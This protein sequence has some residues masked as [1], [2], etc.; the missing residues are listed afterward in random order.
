MGVSKRKHFHLPTVWG[1]Y[2]TV[3]IGVI[4]EY[5]EYAFTSGQCLALAVEYMKSFSAEEA[6]GHRIHVFLHHYDPDKPAGFVHAYVVDDQNRKI[7]IRGYEDE[8]KF[9]ERWKEGDHSEYRETSVIEV[10]VEDAH[11]YETSSLSLYAK[12]M[13]KQRFDAARYFVEP[14]KLRL[15]QQIALGNIK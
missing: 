10:S 2:T 6:K 8:A 7:D 11:K 1:E 3:D 14:L 15:Q 12:G 9:I 4:N 13:Y 5:A